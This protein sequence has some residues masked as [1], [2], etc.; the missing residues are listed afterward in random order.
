M[1]DIHWAMVRSRNRTKMPEHQHC[2]LIFGTGFQAPPPRRRDDGEAVCEEQAILD[3][4]VAGSGP[5]D[6]G[7]C[8]PE[9]HVILDDEKAIEATKSGRLFLRLTTSCAFGRRDHLRLS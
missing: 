8:A 5:R 2:H 9:S 3:G 1:A 4:F 6:A 7:G